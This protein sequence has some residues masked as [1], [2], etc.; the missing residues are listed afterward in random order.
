M[1]PA[2]GKCN[3]VW[4]HLIWWFRRGGMAT[5]SEVIKLDGFEAGDLAATVF[6]VGKP[7]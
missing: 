4:H 1:V 7:N 6:D 5:G 2:R 3:E